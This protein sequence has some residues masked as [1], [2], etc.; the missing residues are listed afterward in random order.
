MKSIQFLKDVFGRVFGTRGASIGKTRLIIDD[1]PLT[2]EIASG[3]AMRIKAKAAR[4]GKSISVSGNISRN[5]RFKIP[6]ESHLH[7]VAIDSRGKRLMNELV[8]CDLTQLCSNRHGCKQTIS[9][10]TELHPKTSDIVKIKVVFHN[11]SHSTC[12][13]GKCRQSCS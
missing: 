6:P 1:L 3:P 9:Y 4:N 10:R 5:R 11:H 7:V 12:V 13:S 8:Q 2:V